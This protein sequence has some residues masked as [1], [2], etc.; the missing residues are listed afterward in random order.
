MTLNDTEV[1]PSEQDLCSLED[2]AC[3]LRLIA[4]L[5]WDIGCAS[6]GK[7]LDI[8]CGTGLMAQALAAFTG[9]EAQGT[10]RSPLAYRMASRRIACRLVTGNALPFQSETFAAV[11]AINV[12]ML[13][14]QKLPFFREAH[15][16][17]RHDGRLL[18]LM[19]D[20]AD[21]NEKPL[22]RFIAG[23]MKASMES[24]GRIDEIMI[25]LHEAGF[26]RVTMRRV[27]LGNVELARRYAERHRSGYLSNTQSQSLESARTVGLRRFVVGADAL[28]AQGIRAHYDW[29]RTLILGERT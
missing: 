18:I 23:S 12:I 13:I 16:V 14:D 19:P 27:K 24:Y 20:A 7:F 3:N 22:Y 8:G 5:A 2:S 21:Y 10:E 1:L 17:L 26:S 4:E 6:P 11:V 15:R 9:L 25:N 28:A 29:E